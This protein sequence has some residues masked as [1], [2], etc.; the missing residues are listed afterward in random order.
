VNDHLITRVRVI[1]SKFSIY[2]RG[3]VGCLP[4][5]TKI[6]ILSDGQPIE[7]R[8]TNLDY[9]AVDAKSELAH[10]GEGELID[11]PRLIASGLR[12]TKKGTFKQGV[13]QNQAE[14]YFNLYNKLSDFFASRYNIPLY[15]SHG[16]LLGAA[17]EGR[18]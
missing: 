13:T 6:K 2:I 7:F 3:A 11:M 9:L 8:D 14:Q 4:L 12:L 18:V 10:T 5:G 15:I 16:T 1:A 17:R